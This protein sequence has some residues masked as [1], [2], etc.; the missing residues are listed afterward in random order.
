MEP[1]IDIIFMILASIILIVVI[2][3]VHELGHFLAA[4]KFGVHVIRFKI[5]FGK[6]LIRR[7]DKRG[8][9][10][11]LGILPLGGYVQMLGEDNPIQEAE[12]DTVKETKLLAEE[13]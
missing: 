12:A 7:F 11:S 1:M 2:V 4:R 9:E 13:S 5:G 3:G 8:T 6:D 10:F